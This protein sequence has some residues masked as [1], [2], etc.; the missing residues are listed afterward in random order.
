[1]DSKKK[2]RSLIQEVISLK[3]ILP[4]SVSKVYNVCGKKDCRC[5]DKKTPQR[6]GPYN[7]LSYTIA[8][9]SSTKF[10]KDNDLSSVLAMQKNFRR[11][12][13]IIQELSLAYMDLVKKDGVDKAQ[14]FASALSIDFNTDNNLSEKRLLHKIDQ[15]TIQVDSWRKKAKN[16]TLEMNAMKARIKQLEKS[17]DKWKACALSNKADNKKK[18]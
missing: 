14:D 7:L 12:K 2:I 11:L 10:I 8:K 13:E 5:K 4:G 9:K 16:K 1:M 15:L 6:H 17:R 18:L 3:G